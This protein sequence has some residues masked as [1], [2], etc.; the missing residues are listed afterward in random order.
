MDASRRGHGILRK[1]RSSRRHKQQWRTRGV[2]IPPAPPAVRIFILL[3]LALLGVTFAWQGVKS[4]RNHPIYTA[5]ARVDYNAVRSNTVQAA[6]APSAPLPWQRDVMVS[7]ESAIQEAQSGNLTASEMDV[8]RASSIIEA[9]RLQLNTA[10]PDFFSSAIQ[11]LDRVSAAH[12]E[13]ERLV[14]HSRLVRIDLAELRSALAGPAPPAGSAGLSEPVETSLDSPGAMPGTSPQDDRAGGSSAAG[15]NDAADGTKGPAVASRE[16]HRVMFNAPRSLAANQD[17]SP[18]TAGGNFVDASLMPDNSEMLEPPSTRLF[19]DNI[20]VE[21]LT[22]QGAAQTLD[23]IH[24]H[25]VIFIGT[26]LRYEGGE[27]DLQN[28]HFIRCTFGFST[29]SRGSQLATAIALGQ[30]ALV[31][32]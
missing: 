24:W 12:P 9:A 11:Q 1:W 5:R 18:V 29:D 26:R 27:V 17:F 21:N 10:G 31:I 15:A 4:L 14:E 19:V 8:D 28:V 32:E 16:D 7:L 6:P 13:N 20:R 2:R 25:N 3:L 23:G 30:Q 22:F